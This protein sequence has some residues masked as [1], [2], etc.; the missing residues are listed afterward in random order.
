MKALSLRQ[1]WAT[2]VM[3]KEKRIET[4]GKVFK[5]A[6]GSYVAIHASKAFG[7]AERNVTDSEP[8]KSVL[9]R[10]GVS[11]MSATHHDLPRGTIVGVAEVGGVF[12]TD[13]ER[14]LTELRRLGSHERAFGNYRPERFGYLLTRFWRCGDIYIH[15][16]GQLGLFELPAGV[17]HRILLALQHH[18]D[19]PDELTSDE[20][21]DEAIAE[22]HRRQAKAEQVDAI[23]ARSNSIGPR[24]DT[25]SP[26]DRMIDKA[27]GR[28]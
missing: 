21:I 14:I 11:L 2:L 24:R 19:L 18:D 15:V 1:P 9:A 20:L 23:L 10:Y 17:V 6:A 5:G 22:A 26:I 12:P 13:S 16:R 28:D 27:V 25:R 3:L 4:R 7:P 8:F